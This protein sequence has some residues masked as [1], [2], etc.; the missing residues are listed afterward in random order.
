M[1][2]TDEQ[3]GDAATD[4]NPAHQVTLSL[5]YIGQ[6]EV[7]QELWQVVMGDN[8]PSTFKGRRRPVEHVSWTDCQKFIYN[9]NIMT[10]MKFRLPTEAEWEY[11]AR[12]G[13]KSQGCKYA[14][15]DNVDD[16]AWYSGNSGDWHYDHMTHDVATKAPNE[17]GLYDMSGNVWECCQDWYGSYEAMSQDNPSGP[18]TGTTRV[19][20]G[21][22]EGNDA[23]GCRVSKRSRFVPSFNDRS[24]GLRLALSN[25]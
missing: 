4:E 16:V 2:A 25:Q 21:G 19:Y 14:G 22:S 9:L 17:L 24:L 12:G 8:N 10:G 1:G 15:S 18:S 7:T 6:T 13:N 23:N 11:A 20:R 3:G 5:F